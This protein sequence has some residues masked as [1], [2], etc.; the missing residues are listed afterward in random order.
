MTWRLEVGGPVVLQSTLPAILRWLRPSPA[1]MRIALCNTILNDAIGCSG[2]RITRRNV[3]GAMIQSTPEH[4]F[5]DFQRPSTVEYAS[6]FDCRYAYTRR[7][8]AVGTWL[9]QMSDMAARD[10]RPSG[11]SE[12]IAGNT[13]VA[14][15]I[16]CH[17]A[18]R[19]L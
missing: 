7:R 6:Y 15:P 13:E 17:N 18:H 2:V 11:A 3:A 4:S 16:S 14:A 12:H 19:V 1:T 8:S 10:K 5:T 9:E